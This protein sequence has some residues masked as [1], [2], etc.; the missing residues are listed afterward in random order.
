MRNGLGAGDGTTPATVRSLP[1]I[2]AALVCIPAL[3]ALPFLGFS[4]YVMA[5]AVSAAAYCILAVGLNLVYGYAG[6][7]SL[8]QVAFWGIGAY[9][10]ALLVVDAG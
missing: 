5:I 1:R 10:A 2:A 7:L 9:V 3:Y 6:L 8:G 4:E